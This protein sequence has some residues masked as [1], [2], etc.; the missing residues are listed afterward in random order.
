MAAAAA[1]I[2]MPAGRFRLPLDLR[3]TELQ[4][5]V[6]EEVRGIPFGSTSTYA[7]VAAAI[8]MPKAIRAVASSCSRS[9]FAFAIPCHRVLH[10]GPV[11]KARGSGREGTQ[12]RWAEY[13]A[14]L[15]A[16]RRTPSI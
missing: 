7:K 4:K 2:A 5:R 15:A 8:G 14:R 6:W 13:E 16:K 11:A 12:Y 1:Y 3:G 10:T 9:W